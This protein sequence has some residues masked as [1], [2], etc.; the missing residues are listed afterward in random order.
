MAPPALK[1]DQDS[2]NFSEGLCWQYPPDTLTEPLEAATVKAGGQPLVLQ[3][4][5]LIPPLETGTWSGICGPIPLPA[6]PQ[7]RVIISGVNRKVLAE[8]RLVAV[9][10]DKT[11]PPGFMERTIIGPGNLGSR[12][13]IC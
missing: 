4:S 3:T 1:G 6:P 2:F 5:P 7:P 9:I 13:Q 12:V 8:G 10:G 11:N